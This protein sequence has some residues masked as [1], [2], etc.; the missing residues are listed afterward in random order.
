MGEP[1]IGEVPCVRRGSSVNRWPIAWHV[2][3]GS[4]SGL[5]TDHRANVF[6]A[7]LAMRGFSTYGKC[8]LQRAGI[9]GSSRAAALWRLPRGV[10]QGV[11]PM[12]A[13]LRRN[14]A[15]RAGF[16]ASNC[17][18][19]NSAACACLCSWP[20]LIHAGG[21]HWQRCKQQ[22]CSN[23]H[24]GVKP[25]KRPAK[26]HR[27]PRHERTFWPIWPDLG[28]H[29]EADTGG[30]FLDFCRCPEGQEQELHHGRCGV[31]RLFGVL[32]AT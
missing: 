22:R 18:S 1:L 23:S 5:M 11:P 26:P 30:H 25:S 31:E 2:R 3:T 21:G 17:F 4:S 32:H 27:N 6:A 9:A 16:S 13:R 12:L 8:G 14:S 15:S 10:R 20:T 28:R 19:K 29:H 7:S 24:F